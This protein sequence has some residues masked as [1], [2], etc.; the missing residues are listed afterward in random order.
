VFTNQES[1]IAMEV[2]GDQILD[3]YLKAPLRDWVEIGSGYSAKREAAAKTV[4]EAAA[5]IENASAKPLLALDAYVGTFRDPWRG[6][7]TVRRENDK[8]ILS[9]SRTKL[10]EG[11]L[12][13]F[14]GISSSSIGTTAP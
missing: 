13:P 4:E 1:G 2:V 12:T 7:A 10:L 8:L 6:E 14:N 9:F 11:A 3:A 5:K